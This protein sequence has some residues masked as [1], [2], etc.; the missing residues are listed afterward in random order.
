[1]IALDLLCDLSTLHSF[2]NKIYIY[3]K[4]KENSCGILFTLVCMPLN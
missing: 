3:K 2:E 1:M 4:K